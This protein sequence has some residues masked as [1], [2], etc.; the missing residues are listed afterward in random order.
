[1][2][3]FAL[4]RFEF[5]IERPGFLLD[6]PPVQRAL[7]SALPCCYTQSCN[8]P[9]PSTMKLLSLIAFTNLT[10]TVVTLAVDVELTYS[11]PTGVDPATYTSIGEFCNNLK[12]GHCCPSRYSFF[13]VAIFHGLQALDIAAVWQAEGTTSDCSGR[14]A[15]SKNG[16]GTKILSGAVGT[17][18]V[19]TGESYI[20]LP[21]SISADRASTPMREAQGIL[22]LITGGEGW[23]SEAASPNLQQQAL[24]MVSLLRNM[25]LNG[26]TLDAAAWPSGL[27]LKKRSEYKRRVAFRKEQGV[28]FV[29]PPPKNTVARP[30]NR[31]WHSL[32]GRECWKPDI[33][34]YRGYNSEIQG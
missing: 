8:S 18:V 34:K 31:E 30:D 29:Q 16:P 26:G 25:L 21:Q 14:V 19:L 27:R 3:D 7:P 10:F 28:A 24:R 13:P 5:N 20:R 17:G 6:N 15:D 23:V 22:G 11:T 4:S 9:I 2:C 32:Q 12:P 33:Q 1:M